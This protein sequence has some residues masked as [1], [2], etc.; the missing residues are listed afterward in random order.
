MTTRKFIVA[1]LLILTMP[2]IG[3]SHAQTGASSRDGSISGEIRSAKDGT[4]LLGA[5]VFLENTV[6]GAATD[7]Q[8]RFRLKGIPPGVYS[9]ACSMIGYTRKVVSHIEVS[10]R[11]VARVTVDLSPLPVQTAPVVVTATN[12]EE[13]LLSVPVSVD[14]VNA[15]T[16]MDLNPT[17]VKDVLQYVPGVRV[18][19][20]QIDIRGYTGYSLGVG[21]RV[22]LLLDGMPL[23]TGDTGEIPWEMIPVDEIER[24]EVVKGAA[25]ALYGSSALGGVI[26]IITRDI[27]STP[28]TDFRIYSGLYDQPYYPQWRWSDKLRGMNGFYASHSQR[29]GNFGIL[30]Y[31]GYGMNNGFRQNDSYER[32]NGFAEMEY[33]FSPFEQLKL[34]SNIA[35]ENQ[36]SFYYWSSLNDPLQPDPAQTNAQTLTTRWNTDLLFKGYSG[37][38]FSYNVK[39]EFFSSFLK[40]DSAGIGA[41]TSFAN[42]A[43]VEAQ[44]TWTP[45][46][47]YRLT[48]GAVGNLDRVI[49]LYYGTHLGLGTAGYFQGEF[50]LMPILRLDAGARYDLQE[51]VGLSPWTSVSPKLG[52]VYT[53]G[54]TTTLRASVARGFRAPSLAELYINEGTPYFPIVPNLSLQPEDSW[55]FEVGGTQF[56]SDHVMLDLAV[57]QSNF[58]NLI[59]ASF[60]STGGKL[61]IMFD[62]VSR[63]RVQGAEVDLK[64]DFFKRI[65]RLDFG[66]TYTWPIDL[67]TGQFLRFRSRDLFYASGTLSYGV[68]SV[69][70]DFRY[71]SK[72]LRL[73]DLL[74]S[75]IPNWNAQVPIELFDAR[76]SINMAHFGLPV[77]IGIHINNLFQYNYVEVPGNLGPIRNF[78]L[79]LEG[80]I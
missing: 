16:I 48:F 19:E 12:H 61:R 51:I 39:G 50:R 56:I 5:S 72:M 45:A 13:S 26:N 29:F 1:V 17:S 66:Y 36:A 6:L 11:K 43:N 27:P 38:K 57:Y 22:L 59:E 18:L 68:F 10:P 53:A 58:S 70:A 28:E 14:V 55:S 4:P 7:V 8:G 79:S 46:E 52:V 78:L 47:N 23:L 37:D 40:Y 80:R 31:G 63:A 32:W 35:H 21:S 9:L 44:G 20:N 71:I 25:S 69:G 73:D 67:T 34:I 76:A 75:F 2:A 60:D 64:T 54:P 24:I 74:Q 41:A 77:T 49:A 62:N 65:L 15:K 3:I 42:E 30:A 33:D